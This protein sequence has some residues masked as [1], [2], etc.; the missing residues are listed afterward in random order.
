MHISDGII[1]TPVCIA[2]HAASAGLLYFTGRKAEAAEI[3][4]MGMTGAALFTAS[5]IQFPVAGTSVHP[6]L[7]GLTGILL[8]RRSFPVIYMALL[9]QAVFFQHG[10]LLSLGLNALN[11]GAGAFAAWLLWRLKGLPE[12]LR[13]AA[14]G[15]LGIMTPALLMTAEFRISSYGSAVALL[16]A[17]YA[18]TGAIEGAIT[19]S[20]VKFFRKVKPEILTN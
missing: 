20:A 2:A 17:I 10:G 13:S 11:M 4:R 9:F 19:L 8:G 3:P 16:L 5:L 12:Y 1:S 18:V 6:G 14:A 15:F 7:F